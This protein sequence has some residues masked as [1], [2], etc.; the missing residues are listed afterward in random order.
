MHRALR[1]TARAASRLRFGESFAKIRVP[2]TGALR[3]VRSCVPRSATTKTAPPA[4][5]RRRRARGAGGAVTLAVARPR[6][7][8]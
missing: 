7:F 8:F 5:R 2:F 3:N 4:R 1:E 6:L